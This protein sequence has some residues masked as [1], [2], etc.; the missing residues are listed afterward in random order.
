MDI[1][2]YTNVVKDG[3]AFLCNRD[4]SGHY[5]CRTPCQIY[6]LKPVAWADFPFN[7]TIPAA[8]HAIAHSEYGANYGVSEVYRADCLHN[9]VHG[10][11]FY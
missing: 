3:E 4:N 11:T 6:P 2:V 5:H 8:S 9:F 1:W 10:R 7:V